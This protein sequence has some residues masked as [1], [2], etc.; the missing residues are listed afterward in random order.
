MRSLLTLKNGIIIPIKGNAMKKFGLKILILTLT[1]CA[2]FCVGGNTV[3]AVEKVYIGGFVTGFDIKTNGA[4]VI[5]A[6]DVITKDGIKSP[7]KNA[8]VAAGDILV[9]V[10]GKKIST[11]YDIE[12]ALKDYK[13]GNVVCIFKKDGKDVVKEITPVVDTSGKYRLGLFVRDGASGIGTVTFVKEDGSFSA[14]GHPV[15]EGDEP[16]SVKG[17]NIYRCSVFGIN[18]GE[19]GKAGELKGVFVGDAPIGNIVKN[20][21]YGIKGNVN[22][23]FDYKSLGSVEVGNA[24]IGDAVIVSTIDGVK[25]EEFKVSIVKAD[26]S[27]STRNLLIKIT[28]KRLI[29]VA[30]GIV[31]GMSGSPVIQDGKM[32]GAVTHVFVNDPTRGYGIS[33]NN[34]L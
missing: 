8:G 10:N 12:L 28:D 27:K 11:P 13:K 2:L 15:F 25:R 6:S 34:M 33:I 5:G 16:A 4:F 20:T 17:G 1:V 32:V 9:S 3:K 30:G 19:R 7:A 21:P 22:E 14:L 26:N 23:K 24:E 31:R 29:S 18:K